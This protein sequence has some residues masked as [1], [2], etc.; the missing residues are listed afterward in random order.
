[1]CGIAG[2]NWEDPGLAKAMAAAIAHRGPDDEGFHI[3]DGISLAFRRLSIIDLSR[4]G[5]QPMP[6]EDRTLWLIFN[7]EI[8]NFR[9]LRAELE[10]K[11]H[12]FSSRADS[13]V[14]LHAYEEEG[15]RC[16]EGL[17]GMFS[18]ALWDSR[19]GE[20][21]LARDRIGIKPLY[22]YWKDGKFLFASEIKAILED[23]AVHPSLDY[24]ALYHFLG[25]EFVPGPRT[26]FENIYKLQ[27]G[28]SL[29]LG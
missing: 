24:Q 19:R 13:E 18:F 9:E 10:A 21:F 27:P 4:N 23:P 12:R 16:L 8:Y 6:N 17:R 28:H 11:G 14:I 26:L 15:E 22:Y 2:F 20:F 3:G 29:R 1:M 25:F 5:A 7:G